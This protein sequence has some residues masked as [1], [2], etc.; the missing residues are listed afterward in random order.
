AAFGDVQFGH[1]LHA[2]N[3]GRLQL[4]RRRVLTDQHTINAVANE[5]FL[6]E[7][8]DLDVTGA[9]LDGLGDHGVHQANYGGLAGHVA[10][11]LQVLRVT[12][13][14]GRIGVVLGGL[15]VV[16]VN[17]VEDLLLRGDPRKYAQPR[18]G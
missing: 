12:L 16:A 3:D 14:R 8:L 10:Q 17:R 13:R 7:W 11:V 5:E 1:Q 6:F 4:T 15:P 18:A 9:L 2:R